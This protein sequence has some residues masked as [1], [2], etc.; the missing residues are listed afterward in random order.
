MTGMLTCFPTGGGILK[1]LFV[2]GCSITSAFFFLSLLSVRF[3][4]ALKR[5]L[6]RILDMLSLLTGVMGAVSLILLSVFDTLRYTMLHRLFLFLFMLGIILSAIFTTIEYR[7][8]GKTHAEQRI[9]TYSYNAKRCVFSLEFLLSIAFG[10]SM[11]KKK[12]NA[13]AILE[14]VI[15]F[16]FTFYVLSFFFDLRPSAGTRVMRVLTNDGRMAEEAGAGN[17]DLEG[18]GLRD[19][20]EMEQTYGPPVSI[21]PTESSSDVEVQQRQAAPIALNQGV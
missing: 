18:G 14:W 20:S 15:A 16:V 19:G 6:E 11:Y 3:H 13:A 4:H 10:V 21:G 2:T 7:R 1:P 5:R 8:L 17:S 9:L 12:Q